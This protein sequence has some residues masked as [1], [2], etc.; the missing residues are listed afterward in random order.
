MQVAAIP[1]S[2]NENAALAS[3][4]DSLRPSGDISRAA[5]ERIAG[6]LLAMMESIG[7][8]EGPRWPSISVTPLGL[9]RTVP[10]DP[11]LT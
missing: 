3:P 7:I 6:D 8:V 4:T 11:T 1:Q 9:Y 5:M 10:R 2:P